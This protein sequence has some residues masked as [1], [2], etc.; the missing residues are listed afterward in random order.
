MGGGGMDKKISK[1]VFVFQDLSILF[2]KSEMDEWQAPGPLLPKHS[3]K[4]SVLL[5]SVIWQRDLIWKLTK[6]EFEHIYPD[7]HTN[8]I[9]I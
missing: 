5:S 8:K 3:R 9:K 1:S 4:T 7:P 6:S 2:K